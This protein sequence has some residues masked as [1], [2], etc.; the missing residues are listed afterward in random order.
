V[1]DWTV[2]LTSVGAAGVTG[3]FGYL[4]VRRST[5]VTKTQTEAENERLRTQH[6]EDHLRNRQ[7][8]TM[9]FS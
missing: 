2:I 3:V 8:P 6:Q 7:G 1:A 4:G 9:P 5:D